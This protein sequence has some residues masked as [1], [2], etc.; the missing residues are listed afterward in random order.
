M[1]FTILS[2]YRKELM[3]IGILEVLLLHFYTL[4]NMAVPGFVMNLIELVFVHGFLFLS[5]FGLFYSFTNDNNVKRFY[6]KRFITVMLPYLLFAIPYYTYFYISKQQHIIPIYSSTISLHSNELITYIGRI[7]TLGYW[8]EGNYNGMW[9]LALTIVLYVLYPLL[10]KTFMILRG[11]VWW[12]LVII[13]LIKLYAFGRHFFPEYCEM[14]N[15]ALTNVY[16]FFVGMLFGKWSYSKEILDIEKMVVLGVLCCFAPH[17]KSIMIMII[18]C[19]LLSKLPDSL[20]IV[21]K[22]LGWLGRYT[23]EIYVLHL[24]II[25][26]F[27]L[28]NIASTLP[29]LGKIAIAYSLSIILAVATNIIKDRIKNKIL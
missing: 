22:C 15:F 21:R 19:F 18:I 25:P 12:L 23:L 8:I 20:N 27:A 4:Q 14:V 24:S 13:M 1:V 7:T 3:G 28:S 29:Y 5:G 11:G 16:M 26:L 10:H 17:F 6:K 9:Y 2:K